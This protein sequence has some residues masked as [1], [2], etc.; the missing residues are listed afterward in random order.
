MIYQEQKDNDFM[1][2]FQLYIK[3]LTFPEQVKYVRMVL[4]ISQSE[5]AEQCGISYSTVSR[6]EREN[7]TPLI[8]MPGKFY[9]FCLRK[10]FELND[11]QVKGDAV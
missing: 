10:G 3:Q 9:S 4:Q 2:E 1:T 11:S 7:R 6:W 5:L 8:A